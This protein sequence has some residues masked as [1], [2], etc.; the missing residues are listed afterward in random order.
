MK[1]IAAQ[2][3]TGAIATTAAT[4]YPAANIYNG[5]SADPWIATGRLVT[6]TLTVGA[7][8]SGI[9]LTG[10][11]GSQVTI[12]VKDGDGATVKSETIDLTGIMDYYQ[13]MTD[14]GSPRTVCA[15]EYPYQ[16]TVHTIE[17]DIDSGSDSVAAEIA[18]AMAGIV[19][20]WPHGERI[21]RTEIEQGSI[22][23]TYAD[24]SPYYIEG[25]MIAQYNITVQLDLTDLFFAFIDGVSR[26][27]KKNP[28]FWW[29]VDGNNVH[30]LAYCRMTTH[31]NG[32]ISN[33]YGALS[34]QL[35]EVLG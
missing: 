13:W 31:P 18:E 15:L 32:A 25:D 16:M 4:A 28:T 9:G 23:D 17:I 24:G 10:V 26:R 14:T 7:G 30:W 8:A 12:T 35:T 20:S 27:V 5:D 3:I 19:Q 33:R 1:C 21:S 6:M 29:L 34:L 22:D 11:V 2:R